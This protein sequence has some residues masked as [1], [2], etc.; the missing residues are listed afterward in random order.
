MKPAEPREPAQPS[1]PIDPGDPGDPRGPFIVPGGP[2]GPGSPDRPLYP[3]V[4]FSP[5]IN[6]YRCMQICAQVC[7]HNHPLINFNQQQDHAAVV[8][9]VVNLFSMYLLSILKCSYLW[10]LEIR[11]GHGDPVLPYSLWSQSQDSLCGPCSLGRQ[12]Q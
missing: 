11:L 8:C 12:R 7:T 1:G 5:E 3:V 9:S 4:P 6:M 2:G 10:V